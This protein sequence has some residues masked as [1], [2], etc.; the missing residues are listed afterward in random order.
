MCDFV[1]EIIDLKN[2]PPPQKKRFEAFFKKRQQLLEREISALNERIK[3]LD[4]VR[5][6]VESGR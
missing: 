3:R 4:R 6:L 2:L 1:G 5:K